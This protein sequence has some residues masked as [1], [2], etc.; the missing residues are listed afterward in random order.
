VSGDV[1]PDE[2]LH[3]LLQHHRTAPAQVGAGSDFEFL[4]ARKF[5]DW[6][7]ESF[8]LRE[9][10]YIGWVG[11]LNLGDEAMYELCRQRFPGIRWSR[12][13]N[14]SYAPSP[15]QFFRRGNRE[16][17]QLLQSMSEELA[18]QRRLRHIATKALHKVAR[19]LGREAGICGG[20][21]YINRNAVA[22]ENY[23]S[24]RK[25][26]G[27]MVPT[28]GTGVIHPEFWSDREEGWVDRRKEWVSVLA[29]LPVVG[30]R[31]PISK[32]LLEDAGA[33]NV[34][35][36]GDPAVAFHKRYALQSPGKR[37]EGR[38]RVGLNPGD[39]SGHQWG[40]AEDVQDSF[41]GLAQW[42]KRSG[43]EVEIIPV[44]QKDVE[45]CLDVARRAALDRS[46][47][48][49]VCYT[50]KSFLRRVE[51]LD[52]M[53]C[54]K[55]HAG[56]LAAAAN[57]PFISLEYQPKCRDFAASI[58]WEDFVV[59]TDQLE[60]GGLIELVVDLTEQLD[61]RRAKLCGEMCVLTNRFEQYCR[62]IE[63]LLLR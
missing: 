44:W 60:V 9:G 36:C 56:I 15:R 7:S 24:V 38:L 17:D 58:G 34:V 55:L 10:I 6:K 4:W 14:I 22:L 39:C 43:H 53:I 59:R 52:L 13:Q 1:P 51:K 32:A 20:G 3:R 33:R 21:T 40:H 27:G 11:F 63:P 31:G 16:P 28:F 48:S 19:F 37:N 18:T 46:A 12:L 45:A 26:T 49:P 30:V 61:S 5:V 42:L 57:I 2:N 8:L 35:V 62:Q 29:E 50:S 23:L 47:V 54:L 41:V 25:A